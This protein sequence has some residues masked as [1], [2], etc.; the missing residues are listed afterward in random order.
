MVMLLITP[1]SVIW[2]AGLNII[3]AHNKIERTQLGFVSR[4]LLRSVSQ[5]KVQYQTSAN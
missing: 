5:A 3:V 2:L 4:D 1:R